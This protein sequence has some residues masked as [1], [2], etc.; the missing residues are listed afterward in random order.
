MK[1]D[2]AFADALKS[3]YVGLATMERDEGDWG[4]AAYFNNK[5]RSAAMGT[6]VMAQA[7]AER[8]L[9]GDNVKDLTDARAALMS[10]LP[11]AKTSNPAA[12]A[13]AQAMFDCWMQ[14]QEENFQPEDIAKCRADFEAAMKE[15]EPKPM[16]KP[17]PKPVMPSPKPKTFV[18]YFGFDKAN[19]DDT[20]MMIVDKI[21]SYFGDIN[22]ASVDIAG[23]T[24]TMGPSA[25]NTMLAQKR[26]DAVAAALQGKVKGGVIVNAYGEGKLAVATNDEVM[27]GANRRVEVV[28]TP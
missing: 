13:R 5:G 14:E 22:A 16:A 1:G 12:A 23:H 7:I 11:A 27:E 28:V 17:M 24:D 9:P 20:G 18:I 4:D 6:D 2:T 19:V 10:V 25:Y 26:A 3:E 15:L 21:A 8:D